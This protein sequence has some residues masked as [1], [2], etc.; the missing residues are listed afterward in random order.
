MLLRL[1]LGQLLRQ[2]L[3]NDW[4]LRSQN[5][6]LVTFST[7]SHHHCDYLG[8]SEQKNNHCWQDDNQ[9]KEESVA[10]VV[11]VTTFH[12]DFVI[13]FSVVLIIIIFVLVIIFLWN[14]LFLW[15][16]FIC[17]KW[18]AFLVENFSR[19]CFWKIRLETKQLF[20]ITG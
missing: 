6:E 2:F 10:I 5:G 9:W 8:E 20:D 19:V 7:L 16:E 18:S 1:L 13:V 3:V 14:R 11:D 4:V 17:E 15:S 12:N